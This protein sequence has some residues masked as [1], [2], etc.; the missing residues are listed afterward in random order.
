MHFRGADWSLLQKSKK[1]WGRL[2]VG[3]E[4]G[5]ERLVSGVC[6]ADSTKGPHSNRQAVGTKRG[7][8]ENP[9]PVFHSSN[10]Q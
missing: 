1:S 6:K 8:R 4:Q 10:S 5:K 7:A 2:D 9:T 3:W